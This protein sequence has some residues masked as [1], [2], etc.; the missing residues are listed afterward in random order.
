MSYPSTITGSLPTI[1]I[2]PQD[3][4]NIIQRQGIKETLEGMKNYILDDY[5]NW[6]SFDKT[7]R[8]SNHV[9]DGVLELMPIANQQQYSFK[10]VNCHPK[11]PNEGLSTILA[12]G[13][14]ISND[15]GQ[16]DVI[17]EFTLTT[18][19]RTAATSVLA[20]QYLARPNSKRMAIIGNGCQSEFQA[21]AFYHLLGIEELA[22]FDI[23][24]KAS[25]KLAGNLANTSLKIEIFDTVAQAVKNADIITTVTAEY[26]KANI[27]TPEMIEAGMH[28][29]A[30]GGD[31]INKTELHVDVVKNAHVFVEFEPQTRI[32]GELQNMPADFPVTPL[33][34]IFQKGESA[35]QSEEE[36]TLF[37]SVG[38]A[39]E[40][41]S[42]IRYMNDTAIKLGLA[43]PLS[44]TPDLKDP[45]DLFGYL[46]DYANL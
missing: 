15:T 21:L 37:D 2:S 38:F 33:F 45:K 20:A 3:V 11:N 4:A 28:I 17:S 7:S 44:L 30:V 27:I 43:R 14:L 12:F 29:N 6:N 5:L 16:P 31:N 32:E 8:I 36:V 40:D 19:L 13:A 9:P 39:I 42:A 35:R 34:E 23:D 22:L 1:I 24:R 18:A 25:E 10:Y 46:T 41:F 26:S